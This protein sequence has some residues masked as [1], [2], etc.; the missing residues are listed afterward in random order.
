MWRR[1]MS[2]ESLLAI[3]LFLVACAERPA[4]SEI[5]TGD[6]YIPSTA[7]HSGSTAVDPRTHEL[8]HAESVWSFADSAQWVKKRDEILTALMELG[9]SPVACD[10]RPER[11]RFANALYWRASDL[12]F[13]VRAEAMDRQLTTGQRWVASIEVFPHLPLECAGRAN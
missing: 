2:A 6:S 8:R 3:T 4:R 7:G 13:K 12:F 11:R 5:W 10:A 9:G 1:L